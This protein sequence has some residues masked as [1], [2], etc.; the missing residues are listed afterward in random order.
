MPRN[1]S[2]RSRRRSTRRTPWYRKKYDAMSLAAKA[3]KGVWYLK[4][5]VNSEL[6]KS[7]SASSTTISNTGSIIRLVDIAQG[8]GEGQRTG[9][10]ILVR[11][12]NLK[13]AF[14][15][16]ASATD[17]LYRIIIFKDTQQIADTS[18]AI[19]DLLA[20]ASTL[21][22]LN[23]STVGRFKIMKNW[24]FH[25]SNASDTVRNISWYMNMRMHMRYNGSASTDYQKNGIYLLVLSDQ[26]T[27]TPTV[28][29]NKR[30]TYHDN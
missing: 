8:D 30:V 7:D 18:P 5:L 13:L 10:S 14:N 9:N 20:T 2:R 26:A 22:P 4:G 16:N 21:A 3:A 6:L 1:Y 24:F 15:Q 27:N 12:I 29:Y 25:T 17:T 28:Y 23:A 11:G 19:T